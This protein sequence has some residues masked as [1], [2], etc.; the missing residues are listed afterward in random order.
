MESADFHCKTLSFSEFFAQYEH[1]MPAVKLFELS[2]PWL[3]ATHK[4]ML[5]KTDELMVHCLVDGNEKT[6]IALAANSSKI[7]NSSGH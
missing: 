7:I 2:L 3:M 5:Q 6:H 1:Q 4:F